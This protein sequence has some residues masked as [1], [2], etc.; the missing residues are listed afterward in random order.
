MVK[1]NTKN[2]MGEG[3]INI[4]KQTIKNE[5]PINERMDTEELLRRM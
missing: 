3:N 4:F 5:M 1:T 2:L